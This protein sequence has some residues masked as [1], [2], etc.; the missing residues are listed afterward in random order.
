MTPDADTILY[1]LSRK[2][3]PLVIQSP[4]GPVTPK[5]ESAVQGVQVYQAS[6]LPKNLRIHPIGHKGTHFM[7]EASRGVPLY[8]RKKH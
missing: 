1:Q 2:K 8:G 3:H 7:L 6:T 4:D 5:S